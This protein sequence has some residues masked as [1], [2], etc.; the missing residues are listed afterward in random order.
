MNGHVFQLQVEQRKKGQY[1]ETMEQ[2]HVYASNTYKKEIKHLKVLFTQL[3][4][5]NIVKPEQDKKSEL[6][7]ETIYKEE[8]RQYIKDKRSLESTLVAL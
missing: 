3:Q 4:K 8:V 2:L 1:Q 7:D 5:P 6:Y